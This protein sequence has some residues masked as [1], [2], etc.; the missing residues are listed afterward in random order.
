MTV[1]DLPRSLAWS[2]ARLGGAIEQAGTR[3]ARFL[4]ERSARRRLSR[5]DDRMLH[6]I[7]ISR[8]QIGPLTRWPR[9]GNPTDGAHDDRP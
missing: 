5:M 1:I 8:S 2:A 6:D 3:L 4:D 9:G 7:G